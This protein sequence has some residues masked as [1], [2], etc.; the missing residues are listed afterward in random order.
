MG[1]LHPISHQKNGVHGNVL[2]GAA[3]Q[4]LYCDAAGH[5][6]VT[7]A[8]GGAG[9]LL[10]WDGTALVHATPPTVAN[11]PLVS[12]AANAFGW[13]APSGV[14]VV[15]ADVTHAPS[16]TTLSDVTGLLVPIGASATEVWTFKAFLEVTAA[17]TTVDSKWGFTV[18]T[19]ATMRWGAFG[20][21]SILAGYA[22]PGT[23]GT[24]S[25]LATESGTVSFGSANATFGVSLTGKIY[26]GG[27][28]GN[29]QLQFAQDASSATNL[30]VLKNSHIEYRRIVA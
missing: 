5:S 26:G 15:A 29:V 6:A 8:P 13:G 21:G 28:A 9:T 19:A 11:Q 7:A 2:F 24:A 16:S 3:G 23:S 20:A 30:V 22:A 18:P 12:T 27:T 17:N 1:T 4:V 10:S 14:S 25:A